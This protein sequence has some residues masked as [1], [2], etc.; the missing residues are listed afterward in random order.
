MQIFIY[1]SAPCVSYIILLQTGRPDNNLKTTDKH[2]ASATVSTLRDNIFPGIAPKR[3][4]TVQRRVIGSSG[5]PVV[6]PR[7]RSRSRS[8]GRGHRRQDGPPTCRAAP[9]WPVTEPADLLI[10]GKAVPAIA[11]GRRKTCA[12]TEFSAGTT[13]RRNKT[14]RPGAK[15]DPDPPP[16]GA[17]PLRNTNGARST[18]DKFDFEPALYYL[19]RR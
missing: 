11:S 12:A 3:H 2:N 13:S 5:R 10:N 18:R 15:P 17:F 7:S 4:Q 8:S 16:G 9:A 14:H 6:G 19:C 1:I